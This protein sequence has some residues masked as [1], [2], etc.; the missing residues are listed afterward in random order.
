MKQKI[1]AFL[2][3]IFFSL[4]FASFASAH[5]F[6]VQSNPAQNQQV[7]GNLK[8]VTIQ[9]NEEIQPAFLTLEVLDQKGSRVDTDHAQR[10]KKNRTVL[11]NG[12][13]KPLTSGYY[14][15]NWKVVSA[16]GHAVHG[17]IGFHVGQPTESAANGQASSDARSD[18][19]GVDQVVIKWLIYLGLSF[20]FGILFFLKFFNPARNLPIYH[21]K[22]LQRTLW[23]A[24]G[25]LLLGVLLAL[26]LQVTR[27]ADVNWLHAFSG[28]AVGE[29]LMATSFGTPWF[30]Q[31]SSLILC[32][33]LLF[34]LFRTRSERTVRGLLWVLIGLLF[35]F[36]LSKAF[37]GHAASTEDQELRLW[38]VAAD[39]LHLSAAAIWIGS[40]L[41]LLL[42][43]PRSVK[44]N[45]SPELQKKIYWQT[46]HRFSNVALLLV[47]V[48]FLTGLIGTLIHLT[49]FRAFYTSIYG[50]IIIIK[51][52][53]LLIMLLFALYSNMR[54]QKQGD[55]LRKSVLGEL[56]IGLTVLLA[57][58][59]LTNVSP[60]VP[61][62][63]VDE[64][65]FEG[66][67]AKFNNGK[68][69][70]TAHPP[71]VLEDPKK[72]IRAKEKS[73]V[74]TL[75]VEPLKLGP[76]TLYLDVLDH[77]RRARN[78][79]QVVLKI[80]CIDMDMGETQVQ[81]PLAKLGKGFVVNDAF[82]MKHR[83]LINVHVL[84]KDYQTVDKDFIVN[85]K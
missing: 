10:N 52:A 43:L 46:L 58:A 67:S 82:D 16:D 36:S 63:A 19:P 15:M 85:I 34:W 31:I 37:I 57:A 74:L 6:V 44:N 29:T 4:M 50:W 18:L 72:T 83:F 55:F 5:A 33:A 65:T 1:S 9:F 62:A 12:V 60:P 22:A 47:G 68:P 73:Y 32:I 59:V 81:V 78:L 40:L 80:R 53:L 39:F 17:T 26:P 49:S 8:Q 14:R 11:E 13:K 35:V 24:A 3:L 7:N 71:T 30:L 27:N 64:G 84:D 77:G 61:K 79:Q 48:I 42:F 25:I 2:A 38:A 66:F 23:S 75:R 20:F 41:S 45:D 56:L 51:A 54:A 76:N 69:T 28:K 21:Q 70:K